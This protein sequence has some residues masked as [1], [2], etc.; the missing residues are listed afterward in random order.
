MIAVNLES[1]GEFPPLSCRIRTIRSRKGTCRKQPSIRWLSR[2]V[3]RSSLVVKNGKGGGQEEGERTKGTGRF[4]WARR[5]QVHPV[6]LPQVRGGGYSA[7]LPLA[8]WGGRVKG[9]Q[10]H[11]GVP[12]R[13]GSF[14]DT[15]R[16]W[17]SADLLK[18]PAGGKGW[19]AQYNPAQYKGT[20]GT[21]PKETMP[22]TQK[23]N[24]WRRG[25]RVWAVGPY[26][27]DIARTV[28]GTTLNQ[29]LAGVGS[30]D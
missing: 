26:P 14:P 22:S 23:D 18:V 29:E 10:A 7:L 5:L 8:G 9:V 2:R 30:S 11:E 17:D 24:G 28:R 4:C 20:K 3:V 21:W 1:L 6:P 27:G 12:T 15:V 13:G 16:I 19:N 25:I